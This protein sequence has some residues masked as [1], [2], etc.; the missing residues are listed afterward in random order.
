MDNDYA[1]NGY[2]HDMEQ[3]TLYARA[4]T[5]IGQEGGP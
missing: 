3:E 1:A 5:R 2:A 4:R